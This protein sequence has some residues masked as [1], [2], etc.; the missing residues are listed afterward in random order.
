MEWRGEL[1]LLITNKASW[2][3]SENQSITQVKLYKMNLRGSDCALS[4]VI[5]LGNDALFIDA[6]YSYT[7]STSGLENLQGNCVYFTKLMY[8]ASFLISRN[9]IRC[10][11]EVFDLGEDTYRPCRLPNLPVQ[12]PLPILFWPC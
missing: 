8:S 5:S 2:I 7:V 12:L 10:G 11:Y 4:P 9:L 6:N 1:L 3:R